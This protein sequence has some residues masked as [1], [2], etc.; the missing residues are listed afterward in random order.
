MNDAAA[1]V[2]IGIT[3]V[4]N[5]I[6]GPAPSGTGI[7]SD[8]HAGIR[9]MLIGLSSGVGAVADSVIRIASDAIG[10]DSIRDVGIVASALAPLA[11][12]SW[13]ERI[14]GA[15]F[16]YLSQGLKYDLQWAAPQYLPSQ[17]EVDDL[18][19]LKR[20]D[21]GLWEC[22][23]RAN[24][25]IPEHRRMVR[26]TRNTRPDVREEVLLEMRGSQSADDLKFRME[27]LGVTDQRD[28]TAYR[29]LMKFIPG[30]SD[31]IRFMVR[32]SFDPQAV[33]DNGYMEDFGPKFAASPEA[34]AL[35]KAQGVD[36]KTMALFWAAHW[37]IPSYTQLSE[38]LH[39]LRPG[40][41]PPGVKA[42]AA[43]DVKKALQVDDY[44]PAWVERMMAVSY[45]TITRTDLLQWY[46]NGSIE[47]AELIER[48]M[49]TG[50]NEA[51]A[52]EIVR[53]WD[54]EVANRRS[55]RARTWTR[56][57][58]VKAYVAGTLDRIDAMKL[59]LKT[60]PD[61]AEVT[62]VLDEADLIRLTQQRDKCIRSWRARYMKGEFDLATIKRQL[63][64]MGL[65]ELQA[66]NLADGWLC[67]LTSR[68][69]VQ[70]LTVLSRWYRRG[71]IDLP[72][73]RRRLLN[74][75][76]TAAD[77]ERAIYNMVLT[78]Q[79]RRTAQAKS[80][81]KERIAE[82]TRRNRLSK[83]AQR[84]FEGELAAL[85]RMAKDRADEAK[86]AAKEL[87]KAKAAAVKAAAK[88][89]ADAEKA[90]KA[91]IQQ[92]LDAAEE[93]KR[94]GRQDRTGPGSDT[95]ALPPLTTI[96]DDQ[97]SEPNGE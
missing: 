54:F 83:D 97:P 39:R 79:E 11:V 89:K 57:R 48:L 64:L 36:E 91:T 92:S 21:D 65:D 55:N 94:S 63:R 76:Y 25:N 67:E 20:I 86:A 47:R 81:L 84:E 15:P 23:T 22:W 5:Y 88:V 28:V 9:D 51:D 43:E 40:R 46:V 53:N 16:E 95:N 61:P 32:D 26:D 56:D 60:I 3:S 82:F 8:I 45:N 59:L 17:A 58:I 70:S 78:E 33:A 80:A 62:D 29:E 49:D 4:M 72:D 73:I 31:L 19:T 69:K 30:P 75:Q 50:Y 96:G 18:Y 71:L 41:T 66:D 37:N 2:G 1:Y 27:R 87:E 74:L 93:E 34:Q 52:T 7:G 24:G 90:E 42:V 44:A 12:T 38:M 14:T 13:C 68:S 77:A 85:E 6:A 10:T 35:A